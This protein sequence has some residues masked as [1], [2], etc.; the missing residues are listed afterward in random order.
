[1]RSMLAAAAA[2]LDMDRM[3]ETSMWNC[4]LLSPEWCSE[5]CLK[6]VETSANYSVRY[7]AVCHGGSGDGPGYA[8]VT[9]MLCHIQDWVPRVMDRSM[10]ERRTAFCNRD[11]VAAASADH[12]TADVGEGNDCRDHD[13]LEL[14]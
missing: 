10:L 5:E 6:G 2:P 1:M 8:R 4:T 7:H 11:A 3:P 9:S 12:A 14:S 13:S